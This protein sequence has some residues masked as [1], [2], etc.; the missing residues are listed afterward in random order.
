MLTVNYVVHPEFNGNA[1]PPEIRRSDF[2]AL[3]QRRRDVADLLRIVPD[4][5]SSSS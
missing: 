4:E 2:L 1:P 5:I 3:D